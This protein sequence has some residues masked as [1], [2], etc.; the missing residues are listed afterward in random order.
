MALNGVNLAL[1]PAAAEAAWAAIY[2]RLGLSDD[3]LERQF[4]GP[5]FLA[6]L[7]MGNVRGWGGPLP[8]SWH[9]RQRN[10]QLAVTDYMLRLGMVPVLPAFAGHVPSALPG[11]YPNA[12][13]YR[14]NSW[15]KF[16]QN[17][18]CALYLD[19]RDPLFKKLGRL[20]LEELTRN[21]GLGHVYTADP[22]NEVQFEGMTTDLVRAAA[23]AIV[24][25]MRTVDDDAVWLLQN[26]MFVHDPLDWSLERVRALLEA[27]PPGRLLM[28]DL[29]AEQW[30]Q[31]NLY[32]MYYGRPFIWCML[33]NF[34][35]TLGMFGDM[36]RIN[37]DVYAARVATNSTMIGIGLTPEGIYQNYVVYE[38]MLESAW[39]TRPIA[40][41]DAWTADYASRRY[42]CDATAGAWRYLLRSV[43]GSHGSNR[44]RGKYTV[45]RRPSLRLR[46]WAWYASY[47][48]MAAW[49]GFVY[50]TTKCRSLG[51][52]HDL[53]DITRQ[54]LQYR[55]DQLYLG[56]RRAVDA[57]PWA[58]NVTSL[59]FLDALEDMHK[60]LETNYAFS[61]A[62]WLEGA[63]AAAS[64]HDEAFLY[65]TNARYQITLWGPNG[66]VEDYACK[67]WAEVLQHYYIPRWRAFLQAAVTA[68]A[69]G[70]RFDERAVQDAVRASVETAFLSVN[71]DFAGSGD[72]PTVARQL[73]E[74]WAFVPGLDELPPGL[75]PWR[76]L[77]AT[78]TL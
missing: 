59:R 36:A 12:T 78:A 39:R 70:A 54:A 8:D 75:A 15:N 37:R 71:I 44:V 60:M 1:V 16:G 43:Y 73:Y 27:P 56:V 41:L 5:A 7:R 21:S 77:H 57:D 33:H 25:A 28:L 49:R 18:C 6:W 68:E 38:M 62:D 67:Q 26:W 46:P 29:Q 72:A 35:G 32:D 45:T 4:T 53:V 17:Y 3:D 20:F 30:P 10:L 74:K 48:L 23:I 47:D 66:E 19:P 40:D 51:F 9:R 69:R 52:E 24:A 22:F 13:F 31:Y 14:V 64:D 50:A 11:L 55:A 42:G 63:R 65:E 76:S 58:L 34:G 2:R 61:A